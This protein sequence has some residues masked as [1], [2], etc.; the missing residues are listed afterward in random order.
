MSGSPDPAEESSELVYPLLG[1][2]HELY[3]LYKKGRILSSK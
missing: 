3:V 1:I 2:S